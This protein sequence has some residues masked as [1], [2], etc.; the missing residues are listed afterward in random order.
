[1]SETQTTPTTNLISQVEAELEKSAKESLKAKV[2]ELVKKRKDAERVVAGIN[3]EI[4]KA[5]EDFESGV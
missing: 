3:L 5:I 2:K 1:M 4:T